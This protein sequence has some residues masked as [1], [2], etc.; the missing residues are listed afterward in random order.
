MRRERLPCAGGPAR[1]VVLC[2]GPLLLSDLLWLPRLASREKWKLQVLEESVTDD[3]GYKVERPERLPPLVSPALQVPPRSTSRAPV[4]LYTRCR[5]SLPTFLET[6]FLA[7]SRYALCASQSRVPP[8]P[9]RPVADERRVSCVAPFQYESG[10]HRV[11]R[12]PSTENQGRVHTSAA[13]V[14]ILP[15]PSEVGG[16]AGSRH[17]P[18][19]RLF[20]AL[21]AAALCAFA[22]VDVELHERD[23]KMETFRAGGAGGQHVNTTDSAVRLIHGPSGVVVEC[24]VERS[25]HQV[26]PLCFLCLG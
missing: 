14:A 7:C 20:A 6:A 4:H 23:V 8:L 24:Q 17:F 22:Q 15:E 13:T 5:K 26:R 10:V 2:A 16:C 12:V 21:T 3:G 1:P 9:A 11:Q 19:L 25:Q 18:G